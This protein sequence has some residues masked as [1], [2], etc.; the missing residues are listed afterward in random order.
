MAGDVV[1]IKVCN[2]IKLR[3]G[4]TGKYYATCHYSY[5]LPLCG[6]KLITVKA[7]IFSLF[8]IL[9]H[10]L[11]A[12]DTKEVYEI[13]PLSQFVG[14]YNVGVKP[15][16]PFFKSRWYLKNSELYTIYDSDI[17][18]KFEPYSGGML[19]YNVVYNESD[20]PEIKESDTTYYLVLT[21]KKDK[22]EQ[23]KVI[24]PR[25][26]WPTDLY[27]YRIPELD[28]LAVNA[29]EQMTQELLTDNFRFIYSKKDEPF[30][31]SF[32]SK[33]ESLYHKL[34]DEFKS[35]PIP[36]TTYKLYP[37]LKSYHNGVLTPGA[38]DWQQG[39][40]WTENE[41]K[42]V[43]PTYLGTELNE[44][45]SDDLLIHEYV[46][47]IHW[48]KVGDPNSIPKWLW[49][50]VALYKGCCAWEEIDQLD[51]IKEGKYPSLKKINWNGEFQYQLGYYLIEFIDKKWGWEKVIELM[52]SNGDIKTVFGFSEKKFEKEF[53]GYLEEKYLK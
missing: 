22:L 28:E 13:R 49:E 42:L 25:K 37:D 41:I 31:K 43:S 29:E 34:L 16:K 5:N 38:P 19:S 47:I 2:P 46:H 21:F 44:S 30:V 48:N 45:I 6:I 3:G 4:L 11:F 32:S 51:Y 9:S 17:D 50:G 14:Y 26:E 23:F 35:E 27:G 52:I 36:V 39:R 12:Q 40:V 20:L 1:N 18:R 15:N 24:R 7:V 8:I 10:S 33:V 53:Y